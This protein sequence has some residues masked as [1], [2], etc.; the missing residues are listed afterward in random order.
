VPHVVNRPNV[1]KV[2]WQLLS[3]VFGLIAGGMVLEVVASN[4]TESNGL[5]WWLALLCFAGAMALA[6]GGIWLA[7]QEGKADGGR[8]G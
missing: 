6:I 3:S 4:S 5:A 1:A 2:K 7:Y 8:F